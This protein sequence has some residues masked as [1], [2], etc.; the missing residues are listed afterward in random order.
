MLFRSYIESLTS[1]FIKRFR[2]IN[3][4][5]DII[6][7]FTINCDLDSEILF[8]ITFLIKKSDFDSNIFDCNNTKSKKKRK[9]NVE[10]IIYY[11][12]YLNYIEN[13]E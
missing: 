4:N 10:T 1:A 7:N 3:Y 9:S 12:R 11:Y 8:N 5:S 6:I 2:N 13:V